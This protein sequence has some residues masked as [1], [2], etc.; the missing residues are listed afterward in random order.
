MFF[1]AV[2]CRHEKNMLK[3]THLG[4]DY[5]DVTINGEEFQ[6]SRQ[7][8][9]A[10]KKVKAQKK[11]F[12]WSLGSQTGANMITKWGINVYILDRFINERGV[13][14]YLVESSEEPEEDED[15]NV[16]DLGKWVLSEYEILR[17]ASI[18]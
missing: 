17:E 4:E 13:N 6:T 12:K 16:I 9:E 3:V 7:V 15:G 1:G 8:G 14:V 5:A 11:P 2:L 18:Y 10:L